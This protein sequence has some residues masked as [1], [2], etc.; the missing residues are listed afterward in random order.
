M[1]EFQS[2]IKMDQ[3]LIDIL[4]NWTPMLLLI[5]VWVFFLQRMRGGYTTK[6]Q[7]DCME[8]T[9]RQA[10]ALERIAKLLEAKTL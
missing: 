3:H 10:E 4:I 9:R 1:S 8:L 7:Q 5:G 2:E 6:Y